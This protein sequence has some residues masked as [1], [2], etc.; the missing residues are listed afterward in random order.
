MYC[1]WCGSVVTKPLAWENNYCQFFLKAFQ[2][3]TRWWNHSHNHS[4]QWFCSESPI[5]ISFHCEIGEVWW[6]VLQS[7]TVVCCVAV[8]LWQQDGTFRGYNSVVTHSPIRRNHWHRFTLSFFVWGFLCLGVQYWHFCFF[9]TLLA[10][11]RGLIA[12][13]RALLICCTLELIALSFKKRGHSNHYLQPACFIFKCL[14]AHLVMLTVSK[15]VM[16]V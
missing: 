3:F 10:R 13:Q 2:S 11:Q 5:I 7:H 15:P 16:A 6:N 9:P 12:G 8:F 14:S 4:T 1:A